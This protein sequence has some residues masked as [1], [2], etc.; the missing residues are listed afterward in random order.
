MTVIKT[1][2]T[3]VAK[4]A[5]VATTVGEKTVLL[6]NDTNLY[7]GLHGVGP[8]IWEVIQ[9][10]TTVD[11]LVEMIST[12]YDVEVKQCERDVREFL[13]EMGEKSLIEIDE[14]PSQ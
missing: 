12:E 8:R 2:T 7:Q 14:S 1:D 4:E 3:V 11:E 13:Q 10:P 6:N 5:H 9:E